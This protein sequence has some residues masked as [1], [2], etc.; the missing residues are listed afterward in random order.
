VVILGQGDVMGHGLLP[1]RASAV[2]S[3][4]DRHAS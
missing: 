4:P 3:L 1:P 2:Q